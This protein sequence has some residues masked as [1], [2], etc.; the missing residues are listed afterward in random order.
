MY[1]FFIT[2]YKL[3]KNHLSDLPYLQQ[4]QNHSSSSTITCIQ[5]ITRNHKT[6]EKSLVG[7]MTWQWADRQ[8][9][10]MS[11]RIRDKCSYICT[12][13]HRPCYENI[14]VGTAYGTGDQLSTQCSAAPS[15]TVFPGLTFF[16]FFSD[17]WKQCYQLL[18]IV[19]INQSTVS[20]CS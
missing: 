6:A 5:H 12:I 15:W 17:V 16:F 8:Q 13:F 20:L 4:H 10:S 7:I 2:P 19:L 14:R 11:S 1:V 3:V 18:K 9:Q